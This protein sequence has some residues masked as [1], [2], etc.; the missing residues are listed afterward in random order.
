MSNAECSEHLF[1]VGKPNIIEKI[2]E[3]KFVDRKLRVCDV[4]ET[5][6]LS[7]T[8]VVSFSMV[9]LGNSKLSSKRVP[10]M[11][12]TNHK[13]SHVTTFMDYLAMLD[14]NP[15]KFLLRCIIADG[16]WAHNSLYIK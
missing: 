6:R 5:I 13:L 12:T 3:M 16:T 2:H 4:V 8:T 14:S 9:Q 1:V 10:L 11:L 7:Y 15:D